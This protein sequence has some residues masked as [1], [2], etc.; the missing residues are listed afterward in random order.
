MLDIQQSGMFL[1]GSLLPTT[2]I[3]EISPAKENNLS[4]IGKLNNQ[5]ITLS[6]KVPTAILCNNPADQ[7][8]VKTQSQPNSLN[9]SIQATLN[10]QGGFI[11]QITT[12]DASKPIKFNAIEEKSQNP[13]SS[14]N[15][16]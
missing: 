7:T 8:S 9:L 14:S 1:N 2:N 12:N 10:S 13:N 11:G 4:L 3:Q 6:G 15:K 5:Q 16:P